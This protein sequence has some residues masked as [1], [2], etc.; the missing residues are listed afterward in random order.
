MTLAQQFWFTLKANQISED[1]TPSLTKVAPDD[2]ESK[3][4]KVFL[5]QKPPEDREEVDR[6]MKGMS[7]KKPFL[8]RDSSYSPY[9]LNCI[10]FSRCFHCKDIAIWIYDRLV[11]PQQGKAPVPNPD[12]PTDIR[13]DY[14]EASTILALSPRGAAA[15]LRLCIQKLCKHL[16]EKGKNPNE[17]IARLVKKGLPE[18]VQ[19]ALDSIRV[20]GGEAVHPGQLDLRDDSGTAETLFELVNFIADIM[21]SKPKRVSEIYNK[22]PQSKIKAIEQRDSK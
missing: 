4:Y 22:L 12:L 9:K 11:W 17:D 16:G 13:T 3:T 1:Q 21:I 14:Q 7:R 8:Q 19:E 6:Y 18:K 5:A 10:H 15:L 20:I 2:L